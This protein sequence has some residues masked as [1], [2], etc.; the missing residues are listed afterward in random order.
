MEEEYSS[1]FKGSEIDAAV[2]AV[3]QKESIWDGKPSKEEV[4]AAIQSAVLD[5]WEASY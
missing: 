5:S 3:R 4:S 2:R 1:A